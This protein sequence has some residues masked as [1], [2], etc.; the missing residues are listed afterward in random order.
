MKWPGEI[1]K[2]SFEEKNI[3]TG[4]EVSPVGGQTYTIEEAARTGPTGPAGSDATRP[5]TA[6]VT[7]PTIGTAPPPAGVTI[8]T[9]NGAVG[10]ESASDEIAQFMARVVPWPENSE[11][12][13]HI[14]L[15]WTFWHGDDPPKNIPWAGIPT[16][17][18]E[19]FMKALDWVRARKNTRDIYFCLSLQSQTR[20]NKRSRVAAARSQKNALALKAIWLDID[21]KDPPKGYATLE[22]AIDDL[23]AFRNSVKLPPPSALVFSGGGLHVYW[24][25]SKPLAPAEW[26]RYAEGLKN[27]AVKFGLRC[28]A[29]CTVDSARVLRV[30]GTLNYKRHE[31]PPV[32]LRWL[33]PGHE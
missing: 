32:S 21:V 20:T 2:P 17:T 24:I 11:A 19:E 16:R 7:D 1:M 25:S 29:G 6:G 18:V 3:L 31:K 28:D 33:E 10:R 9:A 15:H 14:N 26:K 23:T 30:P 4:Q 8:I 13:G 22:D 5:P 12:P 27:A